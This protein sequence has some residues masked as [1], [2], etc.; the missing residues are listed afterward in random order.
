MRVL[1]CFFLFTLSA[2]QPS[3]TIDANE[4]IEI[5]V[6]VLMLDQSVEYFS[7]PKGS[8]LDVLLAQI[9][10]S[11]CDLARL[12]PKQVLYPY[13]QIVLYPKGKDCISINQ[14][15]LEELDELNGI[16]PAIAQRIID[17]R[18]EFGFFQRLED[19]M[20]V[21]GIK[22]K[23]FE[24]VKDVICLCVKPYIFFRF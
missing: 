23:L 16:G 18:L 17:Y 12:N 6:S 22:E 21:K 4:T 15:T 3:Q 10:C 8:T 13:D 2:C 5:E 9:E 20:K 11:D 1:L 7:L 24:K 19:L 14:S